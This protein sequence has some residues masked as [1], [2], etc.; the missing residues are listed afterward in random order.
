M[1]VVAWVCWVLGWCRGPGSVGY[2]MGGWD[3]VRCS[4]GVFFLKMSL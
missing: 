3:L 4:A 1:C 2:V